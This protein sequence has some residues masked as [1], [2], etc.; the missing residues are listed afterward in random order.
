MIFF[1]FYHELQNLKNFQISDLWF[2]EVENN[3]MISDFIQYMR[4]PTFLDE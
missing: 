1:Y 2:F 4:F 3:N